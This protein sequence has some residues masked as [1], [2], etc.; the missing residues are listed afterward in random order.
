MIDTTSLSILQYNVQKSK[1]ITMAPLLADPEVQK[2]HI[3]AIQEPWKN[4]T[5]H[6]SYNPSSSAFHLVYRPKENT[7]VAFYINKELEVES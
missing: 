2:Y 3:L 4:P 5:I 1:N 7:R 6:T